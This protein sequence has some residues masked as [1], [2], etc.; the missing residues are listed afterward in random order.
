MKKKIAAIITLSAL[1]SIAIGAALLWRAHRISDIVS[2]G[3]AYEGR[4]EHKTIRPLPPG[5]AVDDLQDCTVPASFTPEDFHWMGGN[6]RLKVYCKDLYDAVDI[7]RLSAGDTLVYDSQN[8]VVSSIDSSHGVID[9]NGGLDEGGCCLVGYEGGTYIARNWDD[10]ATY[11]YLG[12]AEI[13]LAQDF[14]I[15]DCG[16]FPTDPSDTIRTGQKLYIENLTGGRDDFFQLNTLV[17][18]ENGMISR[19]ERRWIP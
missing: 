12:T 6:L 3:S 10:H 14:I 11:T 15:V 8:M 2:D 17:T 9:I 7:S 1:A 5:V 18:V 19:I 16:E 4:A 13:A